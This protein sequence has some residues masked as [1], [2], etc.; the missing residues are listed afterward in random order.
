MKQAVR[1]EVPVRR[2]REASGYGAMSSSSGKERRWLSFL[3]LIV[4]NEGR[5]ARGAR[6]TMSAAIDR[7]PFRR[8]VGRAW[9]SKTK[10]LSCSMSS[11][12]SRSKLVPMSTC[13]NGHAPPWCELSHCGG[14]LVV[15]W[16]E[17]EELWWLFWLGQGLIVF[18]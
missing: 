12:G 1:R 11:C 5:L 18:V 14:V 16:R 6:A 9:K 2:V 17:D 7:L 15:L 3:R 8:F 13:C 4:C 10:R